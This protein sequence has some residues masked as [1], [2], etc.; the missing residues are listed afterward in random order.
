MTIRSGGDGS[1]QMRR[2]ARVTVL[3]MRFVT[4]LRRTATVLL[5]LFMLACVLALWNTDAPQFIYVA[6]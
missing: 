2:A 6:F 5:Y 1:P 3:P 4:A